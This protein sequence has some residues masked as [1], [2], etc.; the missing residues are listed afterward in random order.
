MKI[1]DYLAAT[2]SKWPHQSVTVKPMSH[3]DD[4]E[5]DGYIVTMI[6]GN[7]QVAYR[8]D[9]E[10]ALEIDGWINHALRAAVKKGSPVSIYTAKDEA[11]HEVEASR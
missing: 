9:L 2:Q 7:K 4:L 1:A 8:V 3:W 10:T 11:E 5:G 6:V